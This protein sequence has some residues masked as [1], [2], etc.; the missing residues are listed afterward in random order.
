ME[1]DKGGKLILCQKLREKAYR[2][3]GMESEEGED[4][5]YENEE[6]MHGDTQDRIGGWTGVRP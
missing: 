1:S 5:S 6:T 2:V 3:E 4:R